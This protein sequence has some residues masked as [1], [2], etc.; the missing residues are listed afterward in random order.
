MREQRAISKFAVERYIKNSYERSDGLIRKTVN[1]YS[2]IVVDGKEKINL[3]MKKRLRKNISKSFDVSL[4]MTRD[5]VIINISKSFD[6]RRSLWKT[7]GKGWSQIGR[8]SC[9]ERVS[10]PV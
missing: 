2:C 6:V 4:D 1:S 9:R 5:S 3:F 8:A 10:S 7:I